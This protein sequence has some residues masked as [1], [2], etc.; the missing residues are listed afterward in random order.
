MGNPLI[1]ELIIGTGSKDRSAWTIPTTIA[2]LRTSFW[3]RFW[4]RSLTSIGIP[5]PHPPRHRSAA[6]GALYASDLSGLYAR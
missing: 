6:A 1:N 4:P 2:S 5:V 3:I